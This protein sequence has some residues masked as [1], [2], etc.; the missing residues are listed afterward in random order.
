MRRLTIIILLAALCFHVNAQDKRWGNPEMF[1]KIKA[2]KISFFTSK[3]DL[4]PSE[5]QAF[6]P[7]YNEFEKKRFDIMREKHKF[8]RMPDEEFAKLNEA[9]LEKMTNSYIQSFEA[10]AQLL[11]D[12]NKQFLKI[13]PKKKVLMMYRTE[14]EFRSHLIKDFRRNNNG[15]RD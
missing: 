5:A 14:N 6:W 13:L 3:L 2:E 8:E 7:V 15:K 4:T 10:E 1:E 9:E 12:Y 11:K